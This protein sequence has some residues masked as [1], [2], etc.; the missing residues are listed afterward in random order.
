MTEHHSRFGTTAYPRHGRRG[1][2]ATPSRYRIDYKRVV[3]NDGDGRQWET[4]LKAW[5]YPT[6]AVAWEAR[7][8]IA[9]LGYHGRFEDEP[10]VFF[11]AIDALADKVKFADCFD[12]SSEVVPSRKALEA[13]GELDARFFCESRE[14]WQISTAGVVRMLL[15]MDRCR[16]ALFLQGSCSCRLRLLAGGVSG[17]LLVG[18]RGRGM[19]HSGPGA[20]H[21]PALRGRFAAVPG[22]HLRGRQGRP[23]LDARVPASGMLQ[24]VLRL[25]L[26]SGG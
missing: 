25:V 24:G 23:S 8:I 11:K 3:C 1:S 10:K 19:W 21:V 5:V 17:A 16:R 6:Q 4:E 14:E 26:Q 7:R 12:L 15:V 22:R 13:R 9:A 20:Q 18:W 2:M